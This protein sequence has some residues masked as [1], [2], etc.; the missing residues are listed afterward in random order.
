MNGL[1]ET[2]LTKFLV[3]VKQENKKFYGECK[4][5]YSRKLNRPMY[6]LD[7]VQRQQMSSQEMSIW[8]FKKVMTYLGLITSN[9][10]EFGILV[11]ASKIL[12]YDND[13]NLL[14]MY[15][16]TDEEKLLGVYVLGFDPKA[17]IPIHPGDR[18]YAM[19]KSFE[20]VLLQS[21]PA[22][23]TLSYAEGISETKQVGFSTSGNRMTI[24]NDA[25]SINRKFLQGCCQTSGGC[26]SG[27]RRR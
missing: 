13:R 25:A 9:M 27:V 2:V 18:W 6:I 26:P 5:K 17:F 7:I 19:L 24:R 20:E 10:Q 23:L 21:L 22:K 15:Q 1:F 16:H 14:A 3:H 12:I 4:G 8:Q 11:D